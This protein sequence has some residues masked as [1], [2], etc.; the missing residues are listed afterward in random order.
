MLAEIASELRA[1]LWDC[2]RITTRLADL[3]AGRETAS[4]QALAEALLMA[5]TVE[6]MIR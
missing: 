4:P 5:F 2:A 6:L 1:P 3:D